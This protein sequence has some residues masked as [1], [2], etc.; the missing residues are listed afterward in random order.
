MESNLQVISGEPEQRG[1]PLGRAPRVLLTDTD[2]RPYAARLALVLAQ[3]GCEVSAVYSLHGHPLRKTQVVKHAFPYSALGP[4]ESL[5]RAIAES[6]PD[7]VIPCDDRGARHLLDLHARSLQQGSDGVP[8]TKLIERS[9]GSP[10]GFRVACGRNDLLRIATEEGLRVPATR[11]IATA[12]DLQA[13]QKEQPFPWVLKADETW[14][15]RGVRIA[16]SRSEAD[17]FFRD[18]SSPFRLRRAIKRLLV[19]RDPFWLRP[20]WEGRKPSVVVQAYVEGRPANCAVLCWKGEV[21]AG[22]DVEVVSADGLTGP[23]R[24]VRVVD[25]AEMKL[26]AERIARRLNLSGF[27]GLDF[28]IEQGTGAAYL[29][30]MNPRCTPLCHLRLG[31]GSDM[32]GAL[33]AQLSGQPQPNVRP[34][35]ENDMIAYFPQAMQANSEFLQTSFHD[36]PQAEPDLMHEFLEPWPERSL[37]FRMMKRLDQLKGLAAAAFARKSTGYSGS[38]T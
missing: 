37:L 28:V 33:W 34:V 6:N 19:N 8:L 25:N 38:G 18:V 3:A 14:G 22:T 4:L 30:E 5:A 31:N 17:Q 27:F 9:L 12:E 35:T 2:R 32:I 29:I 15:G 36:V 7:I 26:C 24:V 10:E 13:W 20:W 23:A 1:H 16:H 11:L 21:L